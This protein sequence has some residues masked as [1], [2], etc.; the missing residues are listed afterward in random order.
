MGRDGIVGLWR[1]YIAPVPANKDLGPQGSSATR[2]AN[3]EK[4]HRTSLRLNR[5]ST[6]TPK[7]VRDALPPAGARDAISVKPQGQ[8]PSLTKRIPNSAQRNQTHAQR[9]P[10]PAQRNPNSAQ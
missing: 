10:S 8:L 5:H 4:Q 6:I 3:R 2:L 7:P 1:P 9:N